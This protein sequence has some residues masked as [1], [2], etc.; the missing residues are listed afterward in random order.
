MSEHTPESREVID[1]MWE[2]AFRALAAARR[3]CR[4]LQKVL[5]EPHE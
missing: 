5:G 3:A 2:R 1:A 4:R